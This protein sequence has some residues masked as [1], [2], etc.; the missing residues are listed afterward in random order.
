MFGL[1]VHQYFC[2]GFVINGFGKVL[3]GKCAFD[4]EVVCAFNVAWKS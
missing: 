4:C 3:P 1:D 2:Q